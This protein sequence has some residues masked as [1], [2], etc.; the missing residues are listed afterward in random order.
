MIGAG[1]NPE[2]TVVDLAFNPTNPQVIYLADLFSGVYISKNAGLSWRLINN[3]LTN[4]AVNALALSSDGQHLYAATEGRGVFRLD[5]NGRPPEAM[6]PLVSAT[7]EKPAAN[8]TEIYAAQPTA[9]AP[10]QPTKA[11]EA[12]PTPT[13]GRTRPK[14]RCLSGYAVLGLAVIGFIGWRKGR[15]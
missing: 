1:L 9:Y 6:P 14:L 5:L 4:R 8:A 13:S 3:G 12:T 11:S 7:P 2:A 10:A 15:R